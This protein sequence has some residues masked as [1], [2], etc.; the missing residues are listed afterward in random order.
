MLHQSLQLQK[1]LVYLHYVV[2]FVYL[3]RVVAHF[4]QLGLHIHVE[5]QSVVP[6][7]LTELGHLRL[8]DCVAGTKLRHRYGGTYRVG[9]SH[10]GTPAWPAGTGTLLLFCMRPLL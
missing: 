9:S 6:L 1:T 8:V 4:S 5:I 10:T 2:Q 3:Y 7:W